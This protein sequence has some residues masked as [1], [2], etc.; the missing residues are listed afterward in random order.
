VTPTGYRVSEVTLP[1]YPYAQFLK[2]AGESGPVDYPAQ[3]LDRSAY[4][5]AG[6]RPVAQKHRALILENKYLRLVILPD[7]GGR[8]YEC[9]FK[10]TG[11][12]EFYSNTVIKPTQWGPLAPAGANWWL[13][14]GGLEWGFPVEEHGYEF[15]T[16][17]GFDHAERPDG[18]MMITLYTRNGP[19]NPYVVVDIILPPETAYFV[20]QPRIVNPW[21]QPFRFKWWANAMVAP[22]APNSA[23]PNLNLVLPAREVTVHSTGDGSL[24]GPGQAMSWPVHNGRDFGRLGNWTD[25]LGVFQRPA[26]S[27]N[28]MGV[29][30]PSLDE[31]LIRVYPSS[32]AKGAKLFSPTRI[33]PQNWTD[34]GSTYVEMHGGLEPTF[35]TW[36]ELGP[37]REVTWAEV[38]YPVARIGGVTWAGEGGAVFVTPAAGA[39]RVALFPT[40]AVRGTLT[41]ESP[42]S[43][44]VVRQVDIAPDRPF[45]EDV[46]V[47]GG[48]LRVR[49][50]N[51]AG[52]VVFEYAG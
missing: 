41:V 27:G 5:A 49:L 48:Q 43:A 8:I 42:G 52:V 34:D 33:D 38:W 50:T 37:G 24:P 21:G 13:G 10:P 40:S 23:R 26:A 16:V 32:V 28:F 2:P 4:E 9:V 3:T 45:V 46:P 47:A 51:D 31:G 30:D 19:Q 22:G 15:G 11:N 1:T 39:M 12:N 17:W 14:V 20:V 6:P 36:Y 35:D 18:G 44:A 25:Y 7:L 29:Y